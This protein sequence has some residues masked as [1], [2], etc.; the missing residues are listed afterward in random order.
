M[1]VYRICVLIIVKESI[2]YIMF[3]VVFMIYNEYKYQNTHLIRVMVI[4]NLDGSDIIIKVFNLYIIYCSMSSSTIYVFDIT[5]WSNGQY[6]ECWI[7]KV[8]LM[9]MNMWI[10]NIWIFDIVCK[11]VYFYSLHINQL[12]NGF[13]WFTHYQWIR[14]R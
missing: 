12:Q 4:L 7:A 6:L 2:K 10:K 9:W 5:N 1:L 13:V 14:S 11:W 8:N 3:N